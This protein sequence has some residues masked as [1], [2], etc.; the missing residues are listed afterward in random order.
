LSA[1]GSRWSAILYRP[2]YGLTGWVKWQTGQEVVLRTVTL[3][4]PTNMPPPLH[5]EV[6]ICIPRHTICP[7]DLSL[8]RGPGGIVEADQLVGP[9]NS[10]GLPPH[11]RAQNRIPPVPPSPISLRQSS[12]PEQWPSRG[13]T[14]VTAKLLKFANERQGLSLE[15]FSETGSAASSIHQAERTGVSAPSQKV[16]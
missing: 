4:L 15:N 3:H 5:S 6:I 8:G 11:F 13:V 1:S 7:T 14:D 10:K 2:P 16:L 12:R 9:A